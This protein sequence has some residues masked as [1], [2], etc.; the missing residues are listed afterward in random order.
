MGKIIGFL[1][2]DIRNTVFEAMIGFVVGW[3]VCLIG[4]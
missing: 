3:A 2:R 4:L 1:S